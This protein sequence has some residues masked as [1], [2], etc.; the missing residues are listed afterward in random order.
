MNTENIEDKYNIY[1][2]ARRMI[3]EMNEHGLDI[4]TF[5]DF[6]P[7]IMHS[8]RSRSV[9]DSDISIIKGLVYKSSR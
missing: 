3:D 1:G 7:P 6:W 2:I 5:D 4:D 8:L 9:E